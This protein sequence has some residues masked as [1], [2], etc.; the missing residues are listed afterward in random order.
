MVI[1][2]T[3]QD[4]LRRMELVQAELCA[5]LQVVLQQECLPMV[6][7]SL[8]LELKCSELHVGHVEVGG[9]WRELAVRPLEIVPIAP[10][11]ILDYL[12]LQL[13]RKGKEWVLLRQEPDPVLSEKLVAVLEKQEHRDLPG[14]RELLLHALYL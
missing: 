12:P 13:R 7:G 6:N 8:R 9:L 14:E 1:S 11:R 5:A 3:D 10:L 4:E 2:S